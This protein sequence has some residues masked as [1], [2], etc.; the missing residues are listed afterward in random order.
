MTRRD[1]TDLFDAQ[2]LTAKD[3]GK[4]EDALNTDDL[5]VLVTAVDA[6]V[7]RKL[8]KGAAHRY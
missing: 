4:L 3:I 5:E 7:G 1:D 2:H 6:I 8:K